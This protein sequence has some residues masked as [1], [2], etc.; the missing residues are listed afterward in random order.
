MKLF[1]N[2]DEM[3]GEMKAEMP[4][5]SN[6]AL[7]ALSAHVEREVKNDYETRVQQLG[8]I[9]HPI[10]KQVLSMMEPRDIAR[11]V[12]RIVEADRAVTYVAD[13]ADREGRRQE[14]YG[15]KP[16]QMIRGK[17]QDINYVNSIIPEIGLLGLKAKPVV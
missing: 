14:L 7:E 13:E 6:A 9:R 1:T 10:T 16:W 15:G 4:K 3:I 5:V 17:M 12:K 8:P 11:H 2:I